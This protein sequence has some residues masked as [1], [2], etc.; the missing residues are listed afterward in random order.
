MS[1]GAVDIHSLLPQAAK[2][3]KSSSRKRQSD[4][5]TGDDQPVDGAKKPKKLRKSMTD[6]ISEIG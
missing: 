3:S 6:I 5:T 2:P 1:N 4:D